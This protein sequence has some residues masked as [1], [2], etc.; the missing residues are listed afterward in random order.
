MT[1][2]EFTIVDMPEKVALKNEIGKDVVWCN[3]TYGAESTEA[4]REAFLSAYEVVKDGKHDRD[5]FHTDGDLYQG[6]NKMIVIRRKSD[7]KLFG[8]SYWQ[9]G[10]KYG[11]A[12][13][14]ANGDDHNLP[15]SWDDRTGETIDE[16]YVFLPVVEEPLPAYRFASELEPEEG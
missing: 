8:F 5:W 14:E 3:L 9:G 16:W 13:V 11:E 6:T 10:G 12:M 4:E 2:V 7:G 15:S 1:E